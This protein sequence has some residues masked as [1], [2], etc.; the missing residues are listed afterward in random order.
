MVQRSVFCW[1]FVLAGSREKKKFLL[2]ILRF[3]NF[4]VFWPSENVCFP[5]ENTKYSILGTRKHEPFWRILPPDVFVI[6]GIS[7]AAEAFQSGA[8]SAN[9]G[10][11]RRAILSNPE[12]PST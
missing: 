7:G 12:G 4:G 2:W 11:L 9:F 8:T 10:H 5:I 6:L 1:L 3:N